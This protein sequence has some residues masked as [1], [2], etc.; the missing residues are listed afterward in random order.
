MQAGQE[1][2]QIDAFNAMEYNSR[3]THKTINRDGHGNETM[4]FTDLEG[5]ILA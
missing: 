2:S 5:K 1:L 3:E 4:V